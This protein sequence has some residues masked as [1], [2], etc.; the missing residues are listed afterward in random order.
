MNNVLRSFII[1]IILGINKKTLPS[2]GEM[3]NRCPRG[4]PLDWVLPFRTIEISVRYISMIPITLCHY[5]EAATIAWEL[6]RVSGVAFCNPSTTAEVQACIKSK[7]THLNT[8]FVWGTYVDTHNIKWKI[9]FICPQLFFS[10]EIIQ[11]FPLANSNSQNLPNVSTICHTWRAPH[12]TFFKKLLNHL[13]TTLL[14][15]TTTKTPF[16]TLQ[17]CKKVSIFFPSMPS[18]SHFSIQLGAEKK[19]LWQKITVEYN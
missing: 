19:H 1:K 17:F 10:L 5:L 9:D 15:S 16:W 11:H 14:W 2:F 18:S 4:Y 8:I 3:E 12:D 6:D 7:C 13:G